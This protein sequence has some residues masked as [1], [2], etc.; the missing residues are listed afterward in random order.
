MNEHRIALRRVWHLIRKGHETT[1][2][3]LPATLDPAWGVFHLERSFHWPEAGAATVWLRV[4]RVP[5]LQELRLDNQPLAWPVANEPELV[6][7]GMS[8]GRR[9]LT[10]A[11]DTCGLS[12]IQRVDWGHVWI[13]IRP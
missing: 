7:N 11:V 6:L 5:G 8:G 3:D 9:T 4:E 1:R 13:V 2:I 10:L 12:R